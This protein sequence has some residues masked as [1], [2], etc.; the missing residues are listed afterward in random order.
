MVDA[1]PAQALTAAV[2]VGLILSFHGDVAA[3]AEI[4]GAFFAEGVL[5]KDVFFDLHRAA[6]GCCRK[7]GF[8]GKGRQL[9]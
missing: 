6:V 7:C 8:H 1:G 3:R 2:T 4:I 9:W 5:I